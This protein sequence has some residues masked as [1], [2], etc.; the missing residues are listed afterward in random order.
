[1]IGRLVTKTVGML[2]RSSLRKRMFF[3]AKLPILALGF[4]ALLLT[5]DLLDTLK[6][7][8]TAS[9]I[10]ATAYEQATQIKQQ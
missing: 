4:V 1:M 3:F 2:V 5:T 9:E 6:T 10:A 7:M 8:W